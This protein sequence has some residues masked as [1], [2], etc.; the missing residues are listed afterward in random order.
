MPLPE[1][2]V[3]TQYVAQNKPSKHLLSDDAKE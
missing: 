2:V 1:P 3:W